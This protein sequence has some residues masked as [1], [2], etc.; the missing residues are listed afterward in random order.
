MYLMLLRLTAD[1]SNEPKR[2]YTILFIYDKNPSPAT[3]QESE[4]NKLI[5]VDNAISCTR[6]RRRC[7]FIDSKKQCVVPFW[8]I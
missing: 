5:P 4:L 1:V 2:Y 3:M 7:I 8:F 6:C